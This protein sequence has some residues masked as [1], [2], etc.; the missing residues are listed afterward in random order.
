ME[1]TFQLERMRMDKQLTTVI[2]FTP[3]S[4]DDPLSAFY[5]DTF[6]RHNAQYDHTAITIAKIMCIYYSRS[7]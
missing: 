4:D 7:L 5:W 6:D 3:F 2:P 1:E